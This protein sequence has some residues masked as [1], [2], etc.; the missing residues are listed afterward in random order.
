MYLHFRG[1]G[2]LIQGEKLRGGSIGLSVGKKNYKCELDW[3]IN[4]WKWNK[5]GK[6]VPKPVLL[7]V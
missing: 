4:I 3:G 1:G 7:S 5:D 2:A 6:G